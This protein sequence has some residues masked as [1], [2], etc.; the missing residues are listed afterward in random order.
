MTELLS[1]AQ[2]AETRR[3]SIAAIVDGGIARTDVL[4]PYQQRAVALLE[5]TAVL[6]VEKSRRIGFTWG[7]G[8]YAV[9]RAARERKAGGYDVMYISYSQEMTR[10]FIDACAMWSKAFAQVSSDV[11]EFLFDDTDPENPTETRQIKAFR[12]QFAS[13]FEILALS[14]AP[15]SLRGKQGAVIIDEAAFV[16]DLAQLL[17]AALAF[18]MWGGQV[19]V[20]STH[21]GDANPFNDLCQDVVKGKKPYA[22]MRIDFD[23]ALHDGLYQRI[24][25]VTS[26]DWSAEG[27][28]QWRADIR[29][30]YGD[31]ADEELDCIPSQGSGV[32]ITTA[33]IEACMVRDPAEA[34]VL[35]LERKTDFT[36]L[37]EEVRVAD[38]DAWCETHLKPLLDEL[39]PTLST[40]FGQDFGRVSDLSVMAPL[41]I[42]KSLVRRAPFAVE[43]RNIPF[44][45]Q[46]QVLFYVCDRL[47]RL[48]AL[49]LDRTGN[50]AYLAEV[51]VQRY[52][53]HRT[54]GVHFSE[55]WYRVN[56]PPFKAAF[57]ERAILLPR[58]DEI[59]DDIRG[60]KTIRG[61]IRVPGTRKDDEGGKRHCDA[62]VAYA[63][64]WAASKADPVDYQGYRPARPG[65]G[66]R[67]QDRFSLWD[68]AP[69]AF[70]FRTR[71]GLI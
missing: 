18:L 13:G 10:E 3:A 56:M 6:V 31:A 22:H 30:F 67:R 33:L 54:E 23:Q 68:E 64:A 42:G 46:K 32:A 25:L 71:G 58:D 9:L 20:V 52:G 36:H 51:A 14:S 50:G 40:V 57:E 16:D 29:K 38:I 24:C 17:K 69:D 61:V 34:P 59:R 8:A 7:L 49:K 5:T 26:K 65:E 12:I 1:P 53:E 60:L 2:W 48:T 45:Q 39:D 44:E 66:R 41:Q 4:L 70:E 21:D 47:P 62:A 19:I 43:L 27:E 37:P 28:A 11:G 55:E 35:R 15:R 63:L